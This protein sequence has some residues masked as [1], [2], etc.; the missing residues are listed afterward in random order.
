MAQEPIRNVGESRD[1]YMLPLTGDQMILQ[2]SQ[3]G[4]DLQRE[5]IFNT[6]YRNIKKIVKNT[7]DV[8]AERE[9]QIRV[10][11]TLLVCLIRF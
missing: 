5:A 7:N 4:K 3:I 11:Q 2:Q 1:G 10:P 8:C 6:E 9:T